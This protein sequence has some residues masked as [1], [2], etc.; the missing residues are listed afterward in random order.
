MTMK[1]YTTTSKQKY[2]EMNAIYLNH[3]NCLEF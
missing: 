1:F 2:L 3:F